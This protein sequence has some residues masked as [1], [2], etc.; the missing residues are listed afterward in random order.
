MN[1]LSS[2]FLLALL[3]LMASAQTLINGLYYK[4]F[5]LSTKTCALT[6]GSTKYTGSITIPSSVT[7]R[8][9]SYSVATVDEAAFYYCTNLAS[10]SIPK[11]VASIGSEAFSGCTGLKSITIPNSVTKIGYGA[12]SGCSG[13]ISVTI[14]YCVTSIGNNAFL[15]CT[16]LKSITIPNSVTSIGSSAF[17]DCSSLTSVTIPNSV[18]SIGNNAFQNCSQLGNIYCY[19]ENIPTTGTDVFT[20]SSVELTT[21]Y[22]PSAVMDDYK[23]TE[24]WNGFGAYEVLPLP[25]CATPT[26]NYA[27]GRLTFS[28]DTEDATFSYSVATLSVINTKD[29]DVTMPSKYRVSVYA[30]A[31]G[32]QRSATATKDIEISGIGGIRGDVNNDGQVNMPDAMFIVNKILNG[33]FPDE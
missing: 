18:T 29:T 23:T 12:F 26:I 11:T 8:G 24:P 16:S 5:D 25:Q 22:V 3:P 32:Y 4:D 9:S 21:L 1:K 31:Y 7:Y 17:Q 15:G 30:T 13:L 28:C 27:D 20:G 19:A 2:L 14:L 6:R 33:K 10:V